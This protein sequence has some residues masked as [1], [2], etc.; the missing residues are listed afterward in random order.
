MQTKGYYA[1]ALNLVIEKHSDIRK[2]YLLLK[3]STW[4]GSIARGIEYFPTH[5]RPCIE[6]PFSF[7]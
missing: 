6:S 2:Y 7:L 3:P 5:M 4:A 1:D